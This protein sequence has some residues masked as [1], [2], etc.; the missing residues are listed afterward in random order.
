M[1]FGW[2][3]LRTLRASAMARPERARLFP[4]KAALT[5]LRPGAREPRCRPCTSGTQGAD[6]RWAY[7]QGFAPTA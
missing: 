2:A 5:T 7:N 1:G 3:D 6:N 4:I